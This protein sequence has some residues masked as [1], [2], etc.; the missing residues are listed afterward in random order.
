MKFIMN[1]NIIISILIRYGLIST[2]TLVF[3][4]Q[5][6]I[7]NLQKIFTYLISVLIS[8]FISISFNQNII[9]LQNNVAV[10]IVRECIA[11]SIF[12]LISIIVLSTPIKTAKLFQNYVFLLSI[13]LLFNFLRILT[14]V[15]ISNYSFELAQKIHFLMFEF[16]NAVLI[17]IV[18]FYFLRKKEYNNKY[19]IITD[20]KEIKKEFSK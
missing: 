16:L 17:G 20:I 10:A 4:N 14:I 13:I 15:L 5:T 3:L 19:P 9:F 1:K 6:F 11:P 8:P 7:F 12:I 18:L 2:L